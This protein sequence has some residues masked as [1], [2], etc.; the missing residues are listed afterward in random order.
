M[1]TA[2]IAGG[3]GLIGKH[4]V[5]KLLLS[6]QYRMIYILARRDTGIEHEK[7]KTVVIDFDNIG[8][9]TFDEPID[10][11]F[12]AL[13]T[14]MKQAGSRE[15]FKKFD[16]QYIIAFAAFARRIGASKFMAVSSMGASPKS[17][18][19]YN[20]VKGMTEE[21]LKQIG[22]STLVIFRPSL[23]L[24]ER[25]ELRIA[26]KIS[27]YF[28]KAFNF[29]IPDNYKAIEG[30]KVAGYM[31]KMAQVSTDAVRMV[32]SGEMRQG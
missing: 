27:G 23:L 24:G 19:F 30:E 12:C 6:D 11:A 18:A 5:Q 31:V 8:Q 10:D 32:E 17:P 22:F 2:I 7:V 21:A 15:L 28:M 9:L 16:F 25:T 26:E 3:T 29:L 14:T 4:L 13:G 1:K 20:Q